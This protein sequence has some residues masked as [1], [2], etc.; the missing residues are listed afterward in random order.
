MGFGLRATVTERALRYEIP[1]SFIA[2]RSVSALCGS[3]ARTT[4]PPVALIVYYDFFNLTAPVYCW[5]FLCQLNFSSYTFDRCCGFTDRLRRRTN[6]R[7]VA[8]RVRNFV[9]VLV[10]SCVLLVTDYPRF[11][12]I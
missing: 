11:L 4:R 3:F 5:I 9:K 10:A 6:L 2:K 12:I 1:L 7:N 8:F